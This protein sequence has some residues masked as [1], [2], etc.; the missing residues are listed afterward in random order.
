MAEAAKWR[1]QLLGTLRVLRDG[2]DLGPYPNRT[3]AVLLVGLLSRIDSWMSREEIVQL[4]YPGQDS[5][6]AR[7]ALRQSLRRLRGW[8]GPDSVEIEGSCVR[9]APQ[10]WKAEL[11]D[12]G[13][14][15]RI[16]P[17][18]EHPWMDA[19]RGSWRRL[20]EGAAMEPPAKPFQT[21]V[22]ESSL[23]SRDLGRSLLIGGAQLTEALLPSVVDHLL[24]ITRPRDRRDYLAC[25][26]LEFAARVQM[27]TARFTDFMN[28]A[29]RAHRVAVHRRD[30]SAMART[31]AYLLFSS[32]EAGNLAAARDLIA[33]AG[34]PKRPTS[35]QLLCDTAEAAYHWNCNRLESALAIM[36]RSDHALEGADRLW[37]VQYWR[38]LA[39]L[40]AEADA[41]PLSE[42][43]ERQ[44]R[45]I[46]LPEVEVNVG[47]TL[48]I[49]K[50]TRLISEKR[51]PEAVAIL[52][53]TAKR[54]DETGWPISAL[55][56]QEALAEAYSQCGD[57]GR[58]TATWTRAEARRIR[59]GGRLTPRLL[60]RR[61]RIRSLV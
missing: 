22:E 7:I 37:Q 15:Y 25:E 32:L 45:Q 16:A 8:L 36:Q 59:H 1:V 46:H 38:N 39:V 21:L 19:I 5:A 30:T 52:E 29:A 20:A 60:V 10:A 11:P 28:T 58:A 54:A 2:L 51:F 53:K 23:V 9:L 61:S 43:A 48:D 31:Y 12:P 47:L 44:C 24:E 34:S 57:A 27:R 13:T 35:S 4:L 17:D 6:T 42:E 41:V 33:M 26:Y 55:Y 40:S 49:A 56:A 50:G 18:L 14:G 3:S